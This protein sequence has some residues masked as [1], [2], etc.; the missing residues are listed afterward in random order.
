MRNGAGSNLPFHV[1]KVDPAAS[2]RAGNLMKRHAGLRRSP[3]CG[4]RRDDS[5]GLIRDVPTVDPWDDRRRRAIRLEHR[6][7]LCRGGRNGYLFAGWWTALHF[8]ARNQLVTHNPGVRWRENLGQPSS[9][10]RGY[11]HGSLVGLD[12]DQQLALANGLSGA[13]KPLDDPTATVAVTQVGKPELLDVTHASHPH[14]NLSA[15]PRRRNVA[16]NSGS[17]RPNAL[18]GKGNCR[19]TNANPGGFRFS[20]C[21]TGASGVR[22]H[23]YRGRK[24]DDGSPVGSLFAG[25]APV[26]P[27]P[28]GMP[29]DRR[30]VAPC[31]CFRLL[32]GTCEVPNTPSTDRCLRSCLDFGP[33]IVQRI[34]KGIA[35][36]SVRLRPTLPSLPSLPEG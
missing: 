22:L 26:R 16:M 23:P 27:V 12:L 7:R 17:R 9:F 18:A 28:A 34:P 3:P 25:D 15:P 32:S 24:P 8:H 11:L 19:D 33:I 5:T 30:G 4:R 20:V 29:R 13:D 21:R 35:G 2:A 31:G 14:F 10:G 36:Q 1:R 6:P